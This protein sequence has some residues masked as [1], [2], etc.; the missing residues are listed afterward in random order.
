MKLFF[1]ARYI[2]T[3]FH[4]GIS[5][6]TTELGNALAKL[7][8]VTFI[9]CNPGQRNFLPKGADYI[10]IHEPTS[11]KE[12]FT[13][14]I[15]N[16]Y[17]P[18]VVV[19]PMQTMGAAGRKYKL[20]LTSHDM[21]YYRHRTPPR[22]LPAPIR[23]GWLLY[24][25]TYGPQRIALNSADLVA[26]VSHTSKREFEAAKLTKRPIIVVPNAPQR[27]HSHKV[28][29]DS[30]IIKNIVYMGSFMPYKNVEALIAAMQWLPGKTLHL[31]SR[32][33]P[34]RR[35]ELQALIPK[36][37]DI[38]FYG[39]VSD[40]E[41]EAL[42]ADNAL[43]ATASFDEGYG[44]PIAEALAMGV[45]VAVSDIPIFHE[46]AAGGAVYFDP[47][48]PQDIASAIKRLDDTATR[49]EVIQRG[50]SHMATFTWQ[51]SARELLHAI[52]T[53]V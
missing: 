50:S 11:P 44:L 9:I 24:H 45:P 12:P 34:E 2:R 37:A 32:I 53:L 23:A 8:K 19:S 47:R 27:F 43:L 36:N 3:D 16:K 39:G 26:T 13:A 20:I 5:R 22:N 14:R 40:D 18:D 15:L 29:H 10:E 1:D 42:L 4:D 21:I 6:Y 38:R 33:S 25:L 52:E 35:R 41:Y 7:T 51:A 31:L 28:T 46:V 49:E 17:E 48:R 30:P